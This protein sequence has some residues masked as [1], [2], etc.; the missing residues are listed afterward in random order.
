MVRVLCLHGFAT[1]SAFMQLQMRD[2]IK[3]FPEIQFEYMDG[4]IEM[5]QS[6]VGD[7]SI[8]RVSP[9]KKYYTWKLNVIDGA[10]D[11]SLGDF[12]VAIEKVVEHINKTGPYDGLCGFSMGGGVVEFMTEMY[13][14]GQLNEKLKVA[15]PKFVM[16]CC[17]NYY[18]ENILSYKTPSIHFVGRKDFL[19]EASLLVT[20]KFLNPLVLMNGET[21]KFPKLSQDDIDAIRTYL[22]PITSKAVKTKAP[23]PTKGQALSETLSSNQSNTLKPKL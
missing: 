7:P 10:V 8:I 6:L 12:G 21:H 18:R 22:K 3:A 5:P 1:S 14:K 15:Y 2:F 9:V 4:H 11:Q 20:T 13:E 19:L 16:L 23:L 17:T